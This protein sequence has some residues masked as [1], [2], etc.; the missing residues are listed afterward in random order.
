VADLSD[1][2]DAVIGKLTVFVLGAGASAP[3]GFPL[4]GQLLE[5]IQHDLLQNPSSP[6]FPNDPLSADTNDQMLQQFGRS[7]SPAS[8]HDL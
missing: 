6:S 5:G 4:G 8:L 1:E 3:Y 2:G 7:L